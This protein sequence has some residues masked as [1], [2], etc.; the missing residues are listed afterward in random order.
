MPHLAGPV[1]QATTP[2]LSFFARLYPLDGGEPL[3]LTLDFV[4]DGKIVGRAQPAVPV[5]DERPNR[6]R[7]R[8][9]LE[10]PVPGERTRSG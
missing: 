7:R 4:R 2:N 10:R 1:S 9:P 8:R 5:V 6:L 3:M